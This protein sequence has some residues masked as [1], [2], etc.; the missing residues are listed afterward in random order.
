MDEVEIRRSRFSK[1]AL[2]GRLL[3]SLFITLFWYRVKKFLKKNTNGAFEMVLDKKVLI[4]QS[5]TM[6]FPSPYM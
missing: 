4:N 2:C 6:S 5:T 1:G 3:I